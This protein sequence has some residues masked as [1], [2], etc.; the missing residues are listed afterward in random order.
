MG[1]KMSE[2]AVHVRGDEDAYIRKIVKKLK[3]YKDSHPRASVEIYR[4]NSVSVRIRVVDPDFEKLDIVGRDDLLWSYLDELDE[5]ARSEIT[6]LLLVAPSEVQT[7][8]M[9][10]EFENPRPSML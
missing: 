5:D 4:Q 6:M 10:A 1:Q 9:N 3:R 7:S 2:A 8:F